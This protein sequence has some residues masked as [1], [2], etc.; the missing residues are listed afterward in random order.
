MVAPKPVRTRRRSGVSGFTWHRHPLRANT[1]HVKPERGRS[2]SSIPD[3][4]DGTNLIVADI[5]LRISE[6]ED[7][8]LRLALI[9][10]NVGL[11]GSRRVLDHLIVEASPVLTEKL[12]WW[13]YRFG[14]FFRFLI[15]QHLA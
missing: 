9:I 8:G 1:A 14:F 11:A 3:E 5:L 15:C 6:R 10:P 12:C 2:W 4:S 13:R 7:T